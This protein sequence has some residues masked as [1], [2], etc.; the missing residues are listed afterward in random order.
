MGRVNGFDTMS[1]RELEQVA[2]RRLKRAAELVGMASFDRMMG[3]F[4]VALEKLLQ[5]IA[6]LDGDEDSGLGSTMSAAAVGLNYPPIIQAAAGI[7]EAVGNLELEQ[8][9]MDTPKARSLDDLFSEQ[10]AREAFRQVDY[11]RAARG[12]LIAAGTWDER[13][14]DMA[15]ERA[16]AYGRLEGIFEEDG[17]S[18][19]PIRNDLKA[20]DRRDAED[21][22]RRAVCVGRPESRKERR[23]RERSEAKA[24]RRTG[25]ASSS[26]RRGVA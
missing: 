26:V 4:S 25:S 20:Q 8:G 15:I 22:A 11:L 1:G 21:R 23:A 5:A 18:L 16:N 10:M 7:F 14:L 13:V 3:D 17:V 12:Q 9:K 2:E 6:V 24:A 19:G